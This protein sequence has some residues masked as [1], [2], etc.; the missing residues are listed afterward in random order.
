M[1]LA[2]FVACQSN[3]D[4]VISSTPGVG[5][6]IPEGCVKVYAEVGVGEDTKATYGD[7]LK[8]LWEENDQIALLQ[9]S[10][11]EGSTFNVVNALDIKRGAGTGSAA[12]W[13]DITV[14][15]ELD[16]FY[17]IAY[18]VSAVSFSTTV[19]RNIV[20]TNYDDNVDWNTSGYVGQS[21]GYAAY[22]YNAN[23]SITI[24]STQMGKWEPYMY[25]ATPE[26]VSADGIRATKLTTLNGAFAIRAYEADGVTPKKLSKITITAANSNLSGTYSGVATSYGQ[27]V[28]V[29]G[30]RTGGHYNESV[31]EENAYKN[32]VS[33]L[34][35][36]SATT[37]SRTKSMSLS[38][39]SGSKSVTITDTSAISADENGDYIY[40]LNVAPFENETI[41]IQVVAE[42]GTSLIR[43]ISSATL[44][45]SQ[46]IRC[47]FTWEHAGL[48]NGSIE[49][50]YDSY[51]GNHST[52]LEGGKVYVNDIVVEGVD[53]SAVQ[54]IGVLVYDSANNLVAQSLTDSTL[55]LSQ[56]VVDVATAGTYNVC[57]YAK[58][59]V[60]GEERNL[61]GEMKQVN[62]TP[63]PTDASVI[64]SSYSKNGAVSL[65]NSIYGTT[66]QYTPQL[67]S[68]FPST[69]ISSC[70]LTYGSTTEN[71]TYNSTAT[72][73]LALGQYNCYV[74]ITLG[75]GYVCQSGTYATHITGIPFTMTVSSN[76]DGWSVSGP[77][78]WNKSGG[79]R[80]GF[81]VEHASTSATSLTK[82][83]H[84][85]ADTNISCTANGTIR[86]TLWGSTTFN[87]NVSGSSVYSTKKEGSGSAVS[88]SCSGATGAMKSSS[89]TIQL[90]NSN[91]TNTAN[92]NIF[93]F[94]AI[95]AL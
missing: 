10:A 2:A 35:S 85:P 66:L 92:T 43:Q 76:A 78:D 64:E 15:T 75:N 32:L 47:K 40:Y 31:R 44:A 4:E 21:T 45:A 86:A 63:I 11:N 65:N 18:P 39:G 88:W 1:A 13:G 91:A 52:T 49:T 42:D 28:T 30:A 67:N 55:S 54:S 95:Y 48:T 6:D 5:N 68:T 89:P 27:T 8:A 20:V 81:G 19:S 41:T 61:T 17:Y 84:M 59:V 60:N 90:H 36:Y 57:S 69:F 77:I 72:K 94:K 58:V 82:T 22:T 62:I 16:R 3:Y 25:A 93:A 29:T 7:D 14:P 33:A 34:A 12:F 80:L 79:V 38:L 74:K 9:E 51:A 71:V 50:W 37:T 56:V 53:A 73:T 26:A 70:Q 23:L 24:P 87:I 46:R 83:F